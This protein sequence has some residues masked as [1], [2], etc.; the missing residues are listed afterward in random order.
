MTLNDLERRNGL[1]FVLFN[2]IRVDCVVKQLLGLPQFQ[3]L[4]LIVCDLRSV[5]LFNGYLGKTNSDNSV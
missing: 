5:Q 1:Y 2:R 3:N 4:L